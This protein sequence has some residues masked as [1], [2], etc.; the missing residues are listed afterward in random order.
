MLDA[1]IFDT[2]STASQECETLWKL[3]FVEGTR[4]TETSQPCSSMIDTVAVVPLLRASDGSSLFPEKHGKILRM[5]PSWW[6]FWWLWDRYNQVIGLKIYIISNVLAH[7]LHFIHP[8][9]YLYPCS[10]HQEA[11][12]VLLTFGWS[13]PQH[14]CLRFSEGCFEH[15]QRSNYDRPRWQHETPEASRGQV[16]RSGSPKMRSGK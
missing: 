16:R 6:T 9:L 1:P 5:I 2:T 11:C 14:L 3:M 15:L 4:P 13:V 10:I 7:V 8:Y 12:R